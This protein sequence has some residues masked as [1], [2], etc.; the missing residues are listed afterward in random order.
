MITVKVDMPALNELTG[1]LT[2]RVQRAAERA[3]DATADDMAH[4]IALEIPR[5]FD[6][7]TLYTMKSLLAIK[8]KGHNMIA[9]VVYKEPDR[10]KQHYLVPEIEGGVRHLK[11]FEIHGFNGA[12]FMPGKGAK[13]DAYGN[14]SVGQIKQVMSVLGRAE[15]VAGYSANLTAAS[16][17]RNRKPRDYV[18]LPN[19]SGRLPPGIYQRVQTGV[20]FG[21]KTKKTLPF[22]EYQKGRVRGSFASVIR[23][24]GLKPILI[25]NTKLTYTPRLHFYEIGQKVA[26][27]SFRTHFYRLLSEGM[28]AR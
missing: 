19:G 3:L 20:G 8:T 24:R 10:M 1:L 15:H 13:I 25:R 18:Y 17:K 6:R 22:G 4:A 21:A 5:V 16:A 23:A 2:K 7:P 9:G 14:I 28:A 27:P 26:T 11:G 12:T